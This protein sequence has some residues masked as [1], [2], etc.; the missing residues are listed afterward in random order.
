RNPAQFAE[1][2]KKFSQD[3]GSAGQGGDLG[4]FARDGSMV[5]PFEDAVFG[6]KPGDIVGPVQTDFGWHVI[7]VVTVHPAKLQSFAEVKGEIRRQREQRA[8]SERAQTAGKAKLELLQQGKD[9]GV[10]FGKPVT[11]M[12]NQPQPGIPAGALGGI[13]QADASKL[14]AYVGSVNERGGY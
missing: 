14:P 5:K 2:A 1:L 4:L 6:A 12:R 10:P 7:K 3:P 13:F 8:A 9:A 11:V